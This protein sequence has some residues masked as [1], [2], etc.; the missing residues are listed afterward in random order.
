MSRSGWFWFFIEKDEWFLFYRSGWIIYNDNRGT[1]ASK[2]MKAHHFYDWSVVINVLILVN[3]D[4]RLIALLKTNAKC[5]VHNIQRNK[6]GHFDEITVD[7]CL[8]VYITRYNYDHFHWQMSCLED[9]IKI[10]KIRFDHLTSCQ[11]H[12]KGLTQ[13]YCSAPTPRSSINLLF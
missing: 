10:K 11:V 13:I 8:L 5:Q 1:R 4:C 9:V 3:I 7:D 2:S 12:N 6:F